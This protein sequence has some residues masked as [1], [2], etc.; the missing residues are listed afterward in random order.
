LAEEAV[1]LDPS[2]I[3]A[4]QTLGDALSAAGRKVEG[5]QQ[6]QQALTLAHTTLD[7]GA[8]TMFVPDLEASLKK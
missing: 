8:Q 3:M 1:D 7:P 4:H 2:S 5:R 6:W